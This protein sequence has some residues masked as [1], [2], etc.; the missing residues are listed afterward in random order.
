MPSDDQYTTTSRG[1]R[2]TTVPD[3]DISN[4]ASRKRGQEHGPLTASRQMSRASVARLV[5]MALI[6][7]SGFLWTKLAIR[8]L[9]PAQLV[10]CQLCFAALV[11]LIA[12]AARRVRLPKTLGP[13]AH[14]TV[15][16]IISNI[17]P[18]FL[19]AWGVQRTPSS[20]AGVVLATTPLL[21]L[22]LAFATGS[23]YLSGLRVG[24]LVLGFFGVVMLAAPWRSTVVHGAIAGTG[25]CLLA[26]ICYAV[27]YV[28]SRR[29]LT[30]R[31]VS[32]L[33][34]SAGQ[35]SIAA[36][37]L[38]IT[39]PITFRELPTLGPITIV[40]VV[41]LGV[42]CTGIAYVLNYRLIQDEGASTASTV[43]YLFPIVAVFL[44]VSILNEPIT[45]NLLAG[46]ILV[47]M[48]VAVSR[49]RTS[50]TSVHVP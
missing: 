37:L 3:G 30:G 35:L 1:T 6:Y 14:L 7:G 46:S 10:L 17:V 5:A 19:F 31:G 29:F 27:S 23:E 2:C 28:Y 24:G 12:V 39:A 38:G 40:S 49:A 9:D 15:M 34:L 43:N 25:A 8:S 13:W 45:W 26:G 41:L 44:G 20:V 18:Y 42:L 21:T 16:A 36:L 47:F 11:L 4:P 32:P 22:M 48:G 50:R 33:A